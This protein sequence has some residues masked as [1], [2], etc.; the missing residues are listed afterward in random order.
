MMIQMNL[1]HVSAYSNPQEKSKKKNDYLKYDY[2]HIEYL[3]LN[4]SL[5]KTVFGFFFGVQAKIF[6]K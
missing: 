5:T 4:A 3:T 6:F 2:L 1:A